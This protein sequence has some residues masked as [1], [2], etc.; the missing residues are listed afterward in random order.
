ME[1][2][3]LRAGI[4]PARVCPK[5]GVEVRAHAPS[6]HRAARSRQRM[7][8]VDEVCR[9]DEITRGAASSV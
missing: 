5:N 8:D 7:S 1:L 2:C 9:R 4:A 3:V 6:G